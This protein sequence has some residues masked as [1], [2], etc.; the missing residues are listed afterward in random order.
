MKKVLL[1]SLFIALI[2]F[3]S[4]SLRTVP[5]PTAENC[6]LVKGIVEEVYSPCCEDVF[7]KLKDSDKRFYLNRGLERGIK[8]H[9]IKEDLV[10]HT[11]QLYKID[12]WTPLDPNEHTNPLAQIQLD[13]EIYF[14]VMTEN[15]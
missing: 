3:L 4:L 6:S 2:S 14:S 12:H 13:G 15:H 10:N 7:I 1:F 8:L 9:Q 5:E 11:V